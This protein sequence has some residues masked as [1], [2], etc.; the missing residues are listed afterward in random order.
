[1]A[2]VSTGLPNGGRTAH[3]RIEYDPTLPAGRAL[4]AGLLRTCED[5]Y[6]DMATWFGIDLTDLPIEVRIANQSGGASWSD[7]VTGPPTVTVKPLVAGVATLTQVRYL[8]VAEVTEI[9]MSAQDRG[10]F[11][12]S[13]EGSK[14]EG[15]SRFLSLQFLLAHSLADSTPSGFGVTANWLNSARPNYVDNNPDDIAP[16]VITG[17]T[18]LFLCYLHDQ[19]GFSINEIIAAGADTLGGV[20]RNL[21][22]R[23]DGWIAFRRLVDAH[24]PRP[25]VYYPAAE[26]VFPVPT[27]TT[28]FS[29]G[30][31]TTGYSGT[32]RVVLDRPALVDIPI[33]LTSDDP[34][35]VGV[36]PAVAVPTGELSAEFIVTT[37][38]QPGPFSPKTI[39]L[40]ARYAGRTL[41][42]TVQIQAPQ[43]ARLTVV[44]ASVPAGTA[45]IAT[46]TLARPSLAGDVVANLLSEAPGF[47][48]VPPTVTIPAG[49]LTAT[50][51]VTT[52]P[53]ALPFGTAH[54]DLQAEYAG[55]AVTVRLT[56]TATVVAGRLA[57]L[58]VLPATL[59]GG[60]PAR[61][62][63]KLE[64]AVPTPTV[65]GL[66]AVDADSAHP[67]LPGE[68]STIA[69]TPES[70]TIPAG[71]TTGTFPIHTNRVAQGTRH[72]VT[73]IAG[74]VVT[75]YAA[76]TV[77]G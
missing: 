51:P 57:A 45:A 52:L 59:T 23:S 34:A 36:R 66:A 72:R 4:A 41:P 15:L 12:G 16:D 54:A 73:I 71:L 31:V 26:T 56:V 35:L 6:R 62:T 8:L 75:R 50:F 3:F 69:S 58:T 55:R 9:F 63:V 38:A 49:Q 48:T 1:M 39:G 7:G 43:L 18:T 68:G 2:F 33:G 29:P 21:T 53:N 65:V 44:P 22:G 70:I 61:G 13:D 20:Y 40:H 64:H 60:T 74:A 10:W 28:I 27:L 24:Y 11:A 76:L 67:P 46:L 5:D 19:L 30:S 37:T 25:D 14:G 47:A 17:C 42:T 77:L 32:G